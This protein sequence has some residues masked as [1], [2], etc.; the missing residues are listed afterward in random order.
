[1]ETDPRYVYFLD[2]D[3]FVSTERPG[4]RRRVVTGESLQ[5]C[6]WR[7]DAGAVGSFV[8]HHQDHEQIGIVFRGSL[9]LRI[10]GDGTGERVVLG[11]G[12][13]YLAGH[14]VWHGD[15]IFGGDEEFDECWIL[16]VFAPPRPELGDGV[17]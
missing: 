12:D 4:F 8:H 10:G 13:A 14:G 16:D 5:L 9:A 17:L 3:A 11:P 15:S 7:I 1:M 6:F 2:D